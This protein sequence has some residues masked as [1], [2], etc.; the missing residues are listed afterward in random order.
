[1]KNC[2]M[3]L[4]S[5]PFVLAILA[6]SVLCLNSNNDPR[7]FIERIFVPFNIAGATI[8]YSGL[9]VLIVLYASLREINVQNEYSFLKTGFRRVLILI[10]IIALTNTVSDF[11]SKVIKGFSTD[12]NAIYCYRNN[13]NL[14]T[15]LVTGNYIELNC[16]LRLENRGSV[17]QEFKVKVKYQKGIDDCTM[18]IT[19]GTYIFDKTVKLE[20]HE[21]T[22]IELHDKFKPEAIEKLIWDKDSKEFKFSLFNDKQEVDFFEQ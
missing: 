12:L 8:Y 15:R 14:S 19:Y 4:K 20:P 22:F 16:K 10:L 13:I 21:K 7:P 3:K 6:V 5:L 18:W 11:P 2:R 1:M 17:M 9:V